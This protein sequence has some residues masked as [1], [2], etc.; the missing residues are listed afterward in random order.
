M[1]HR[2]AGKKLGRTPAQRNG[3]EKNLAIALFTHGRITTTRAKAD[4]VRGSAER[5]ITVA[6]RGLARAK[7]A[8]NEAPAV[9]ARRIAASRLYN[10]RDIVQK[11]F[12][13]IAPHFEGRAGG[14]TRIY[15]LNPR[16][17][18]NAEMVLLE[19]VDFAQIN[20]QAESA[21]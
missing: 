19:L 20:E 2:V 15:K 9:H 13:S 17:G 7:E 8:G 21:S 12:T 4:F 1:R 5:L 16:K 18:D 11:L 6:K 3:L 14:Y 10:D